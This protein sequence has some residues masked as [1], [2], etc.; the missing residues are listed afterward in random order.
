MILYNLVKE[1]KSKM[2]H[3]ISI[4]SFS[5]FQKKGVKFIYR[6]IIYASYFAL[7]KKHLSGMYDYL[8]LFHV[9][10]DQIVLS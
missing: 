8:S 6:F 1:G 5:Y 10:S 9:F 7:Y 4:E 2:L 3:I